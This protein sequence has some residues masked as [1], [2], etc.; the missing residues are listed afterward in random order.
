[1][2]FWRSQLFERVTL[3][4]S[5]APAQLAI[6]RTVSGQ[7][8]LLQSGLTLVELIVA[9]TILLI[10]TTMAVPTARYQIRREK[11]K[12]LRQALGEMRTA[13]DQYKDMADQGRSGLKMTP[14]GYPK[15]LQ[16]SGGRRAVAKHTIQRE[17]RAGKC[18]FCAAFPKIR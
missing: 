9:F 12:E 15:T 5:A 14:I 11:E 2:K 8:R 18:A 6:D 1:M 13:I 10:L 17:R 3:C 16:E 4:G 7:R